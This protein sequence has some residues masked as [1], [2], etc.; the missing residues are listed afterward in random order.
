MTCIINHVPAVQVKEK[1]TTLEHDKL[2]TLY[3]CSCNSGNA[4]SWTKSHLFSL[5]LSLSFAFHSKAINL[6]DSS[7]CYKQIKG[8]P[9]L[10]SFSP[11]K[12]TFFCLIIKLNHSL[13]CE[14]YFSWK[15]VLP[16]C[17]PIPQQFQWVTSILPSWTHCQQHPP[18]EGMD[19]F[20]LSL[21]LKCLYVWLKWI[22][23]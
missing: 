20:S 13:P 18:Q 17:R 4:I 14:I 7:M 21:L 8:K 5:S 12:Q 23:K 16:E 10:T 6:G 9:S 19:F 15:T 1:R 11:F 3:I 22:E 2:T